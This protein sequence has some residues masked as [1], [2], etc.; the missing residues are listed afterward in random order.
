MRGT[1][2]LRFYRSGC[3]FPHTAVSVMAEVTDVWSAGGKTNLFGEKVASL[4]CSREAG[5]AVPFTARLR[6]PLTTTY[7]ARRAAAD[8]P[9]MYKMAGELLPAVINCRHRVGVSRTSIFGTIR[10]LRL[11]P[12]DSPFCVRAMSRKPWTLARFAHCRPSRA[13]PLCIF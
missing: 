6:R 3:D 12:T 10:H 11:S 7:T 2:I 9:N 8:D 1:R 5:A 4:R 13:V